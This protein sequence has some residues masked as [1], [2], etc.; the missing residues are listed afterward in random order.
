MNFFYVYKGDA[1]PLFSPE[2]RRG[3]LAAVFS[4]VILQV[5]NTPTLTLAVEGRNEDD[6]SFTTMGT[7]SAI[8]TAGVKFLDQG[9]LKEIL[10]FRFDVAGA[11]AN[12][13]VCVEMV[14]P[15][16]RPYT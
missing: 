6:T 8:T 12:S 9:T 7:F 11:S 13:G 16:W 10:R 3:G 15:Q 5:L 14:G 4:C 1:N 2:F